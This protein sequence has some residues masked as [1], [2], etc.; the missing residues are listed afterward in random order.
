MIIFYTHGLAEIYKMFRICGCWCELN[1]CCKSSTS[2][3]LTPIITIFGNG[4][5]AVGE[6]IEVVT[7]A[8]LRELYCAFGYAQL[9][10]AVITLTPNYISVT[11]CNEGTFIAMLAP[12]TERGIFVG[13]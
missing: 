6:F 3:H 5:A 11:T 1:V 12:P 7:P 2:A 10:P 4:T 9:D 13:Q 8:Q